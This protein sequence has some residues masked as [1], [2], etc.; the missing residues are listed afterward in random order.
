MCQECIKSPYRSNNDK[1]DSFSVVLKQ[2]QLRG[3]HYP[4]SESFDSS[5]QC[6]GLNTNQKTQIDHNLSTMFLYIVREL[7]RNYNGGDR[8]IERP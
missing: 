2:L 3:S 8:L 1:K 7:G 4:L 6:I 5:K